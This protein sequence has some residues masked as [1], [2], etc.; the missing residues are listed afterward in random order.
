MEK[1]VEVGK[2]RGW[3]KE[4]R[5][6]AKRRHA[7]SRALPG[8]IAAGREAWPRSKNYQDK[9]CPESLFSSPWRI[10]TGLAGG[11][12]DGYF[13]SDAGDRG[14]NPATGSMPVWFK[15]KDT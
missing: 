5:Y 15:W 13:A 12:D 10:L 2:F 8:I 1:Q 9:S 7:R 4:R 3:L 6:F 14:S 11:E